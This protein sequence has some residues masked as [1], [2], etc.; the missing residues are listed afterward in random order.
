MIL[1]AC[2]LISKLKLAERNSDFIPT[3]GI[4][5]PDYL[6]LPKNQKSVGNCFIFAAI[7][8]IETAYAVLTGTRYY[9][10][11]EQVSKN[12]Y[13]FYQNH[14]DSENE[15]VS[16]CKAKTSPVSENGYP[17]CVLLYIKEKG[18]MSEYDFPYLEVTS[19]NKYNPK[20]VMPINVTNITQILTIETDPGK[21]RIIEEKY[22]NDEKKGQ[23][24]LTEGTE[25]EIYEKIHNYIVDKL[26]EEKV[27]PIVASICGSMLDGYKIN[28][29]NKE[30]SINHAVTITS[31]GHFPDD[32]DIYYEFVNSHGKYTGDQGKFYVKIY[33]AAT[34]LF[35]NNR[36]IF[37]FIFHCNVIHSPYSAFTLSNTKNNCESCDG[38]MDFQKKERNKMKTIFIVNI[39]ILVLAVVIII[40]ILVSNFACRNNNR[41]DSTLEDIK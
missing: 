37:T 39:V 27:V 2:L 8:C 29:Y 13:N 18:I 15:L 16:L 38:N 33:D 4:K 41:R 1:I 3:Y 25:N 11:A 32:N 22:I 14:Q 31:V 21:Y 6:P 35:W 26:S 28:S 20:Y 36:K 12:I 23:V 19:T 30:C 10:S 34:N 17:S 40:L 24:S 7:S 5:D 9:L